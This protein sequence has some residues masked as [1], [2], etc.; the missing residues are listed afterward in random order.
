MCTLTLREVSCL[1]CSPAC[2]GVRPGM[3]VLTPCHTLNTGHVGLWTPAHT[4]AHSTYTGGARTTRV[5]THACTRV[6]A[7]TAHTADKNMRV[8]VLSRPASVRTQETKGKETTWPMAELKLPHPLGQGPWGAGR[9]RK[10]RELGEGAGLGG[11]ILVEPD[12]GGGGQGS[13]S[14]REGGGGGTRSATRLLAPLPSSSV[15][16]LWAQAP[17]HPG[18]RGGVQGLFLILGPLALPAPHVG[19]CSLSLCTKGARLS[20]KTRLPCP[21]LR[22]DN[23]GRPYRARDATGPKLLTQALWTQETLWL[24]LESPHRGSLWGVPRPYAWVPAIS[25]PWPLVPGPRRAQVA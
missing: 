2:V 8:H 20:S 23:S 7:N 6:L 25:A 9:G 17:P 19:P 14:P 16:T 15:P 12:G 13:R 22:G 1:T 10:H 4:C 21:R 18:A 5:H 3:C 11:A 24:P